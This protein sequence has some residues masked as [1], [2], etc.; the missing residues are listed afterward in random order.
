M[1]LRYARAAVAADPLDEAAYRGLMQAYALTGEP[2]R[3]LAAYEELRT[4][5][6]AELGVD[7]TRATRDLH[8]AILQDR[9]PEPAR[10]MT[11]GI[12]PASGPA[13]VTASAPELVDTSC[14]VRSGGSALVLVVG[15]NG[16]TSADA[17]EHQI[18]ALIRFAQAMGSVIGQVPDSCTVRWPGPAPRR[19]PLDIS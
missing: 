7:P 5:L 18:S 1:A 13:A 15:T 4:T 14:L 11:T 6:A 3:A 9:V 16:P 8:V 12:R 19:P 17:W 2:A 10:S